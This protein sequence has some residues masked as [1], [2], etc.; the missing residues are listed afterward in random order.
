MDSS[1]LIILSLSGGIIIFFTALSI[2][3]LI[4][5]SSNKTLTEESKYQALSTQ[6]NRKRKVANEASEAYLLLQ[7]E[8]LT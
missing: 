5:S 1:L 6:Q 4:F 8:H 3:S 2:L 7:E